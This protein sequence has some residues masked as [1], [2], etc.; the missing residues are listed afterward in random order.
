MNTTSQTEAVAF[1]AAICDE[2]ADD[3]IRLA[4]A[5]WLEERGD[6]RGEFIR[7]QVELAGPW[8]RKGCFCAVRGSGELVSECLGC[9]LRRRERELL[10]YIPSSYDY[11][12][13]DPVKAPGWCGGTA[14]NHWGLRAFLS[15]QP[16]GLLYDNRLTWTFR[17]GFVHAVTCSAEDWMRHA[18]AILSVQP[19]QEVTLTT[20]PSDNELV[21]LVAGL[22]MDRKLVGAGGWLVQNLFIIKWPSI[23]K[24]NLSE[25]VIVRQPG[26]TPETEELSG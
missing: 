3:A 25:T 21:A 22:R 12:K 24:W 8:T 16:T 20:W 6:P 2:P 7:V 1:L 10:S 15:L 17:R 5:D 23:K 19:V 14:E 4:F 11:D 13:S 26:G 18:D 9:R